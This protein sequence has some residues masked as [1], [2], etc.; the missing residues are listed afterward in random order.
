MSSRPVALDSPFELDSTLRRLSCGG[1]SVAL[2]GRWDVAFLHALVAGGHFGPGRSGSART[3]EQGMATFGLHSP[4]TATQWSR[5]VERV[6]AALL[7]LDPGG[8]LARRLGHPPRG[9]TTGPWWWVLRDGEAPPVLA[10]DDLPATTAQAESP[11]LATAT[12]EALALATPIDD[13]TPARLANEFKLVLEAMW[14]ADP[15]Y[16]LDLLADASRWK[17]ESAAL[18]KLRRLRRAEVL[19]SIGAHGRAARLLETLA[20][21]RSDPLLARLFASHIRL[22]RMRVAYASD[23][24]GHYVGLRRELHRTLAGRPD[25]AGD[26]GDAMAWAEKLHLL[27]LCERR[28]L[29]QEFGHEAADPLGTPQL[30]AM[31]RAAHAALLLFLLVRCYDKA[32][33]VC[34]NLAYAHQRL[35]PRLGEPHWALAIR[36][37]ELSFGMH[38]AFGGAESSAWEYIYLGEFWLGSPQA[39]AACRRPGRGAS[40]D[41]HTPDHLAFYDR[42]CRIAAQLGDP[43]QVAYTLLN[44]YRFALDAGPGKV[45]DEALRHLRSHLRAHPEL[46]RL[47]ES[48]G[49]VLPK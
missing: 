49:Y 10:G 23:P 35:A 24:M 32:Q 22:A 47:L 34:A 14:K 17:G 19:Q 27:A 26:C 33:H 36:W 15:K 25:R 44:R 42:A 40:W 16:A 18:S 11:G 45:R 9:K 2:T 37:H 46:V 41:D 3:L 20:G 5:I 4:L 7:Q 31:L 8:G 12:P 30:H 28:V 13:E 48:E 38:A 43:R 39:R 6:R 29:E 1:R 21:E